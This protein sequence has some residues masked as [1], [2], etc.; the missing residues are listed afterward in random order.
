MGR[1]GGVRGAAF[2]A[3]VLV[4]LA[5][6]LAIFGMG[7]AVPVF[8]LV[9]GSEFG[10]HVV[11]DVAFFGLIW[12]GIVGMLTQLWR[13]RRRGAGLLQTVVVFAGFLVVIALVGAFIGPAILGEAPFLALVF[14]PAAVA[15]LVH[16]A[17]R[18]LLSERGRFSPLVAALAVVA[19]I[20]LG[21]YAADQFALQ[22]SGDE[23]AVI[24]HY[25]GMVVYAGSVVALGL[26]AALKPTGWRIPLF[27][28]AGLAVLLG[29]ISAVVPGAASS[30]GT[31]GGALAILWGVAFV[32]A[33]E[34]EAR[35]VPDERR[36]VEP[37][38]RAG[39]AQ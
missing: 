6:P 15:A 7:L 18:A 3:L 36:T 9:E 4:G 38:G 16:P 28:A 24:N 17:G 23:H 21:F 20:P 14:G 26:L 29:L 19:A 32:A 30:L 11:H 8:G 12:A 22:A 2:Y 34:W 13:S 25:A 33:G 5:I 27:S 37:M 10:I 35:R 1:I 31:T 39:R